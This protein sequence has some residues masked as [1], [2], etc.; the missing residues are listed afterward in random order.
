MAVKHSDRRKRVNA[1][2]QLPPLAQRQTAARKEARNERKQ[3][4]LG[5]ARHIGTLTGIVNAQSM[6]LSRGLFGRLKW[7]LVG[8]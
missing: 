8:R 2:G 4:R 1:H 3:F 6:L 5:M 7:M